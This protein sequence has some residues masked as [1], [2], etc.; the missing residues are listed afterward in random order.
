MYKRNWQ[1]T[2]TFKTDAR[3]GFGIPQNYGYYLLHNPTR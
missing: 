3:F 1:K 2:D